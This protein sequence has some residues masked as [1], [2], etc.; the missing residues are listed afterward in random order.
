MLHLLCTLQTLAGNLRS[1][2][3]SRLSEERG[4][5]TV[6]WVLITGFLIVIAALVGRVI[7]SLVQDASSNL[8]VPSLENGS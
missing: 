6:E 3:T 4:G 7:Y 2:I 8:K 5:S 1:R